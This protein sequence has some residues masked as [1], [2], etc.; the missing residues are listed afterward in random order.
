[1]PKTILSKMS[2]ARRHTG[3]AKPGDTSGTKAHIGVTS[4]ELAENETNTKLCHV[5]ETR[6]AEKASRTFRVA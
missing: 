5:R 1:M 2:Y 6:L 3:F 4:N